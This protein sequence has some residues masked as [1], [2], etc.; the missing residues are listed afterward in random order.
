MRAGPYWP[1]NRILQH[2][3]RLHHADGA[4]QFG[5]LVAH[6]IGAKGRAGLHG[7]GSH[8]LRQVILNH[9]AQRSGFL[10]I[11]AAALHAD[12]FR[13]GDLHVVHVPAIPQRLE[14]AVAEA[15]CQDV[16]DGFFTEVMVDAIDFGFFES[17]VQ[18]VAELLG[19]G[20]VVTERLF[21]DDAAPALPPLPTLALARP[22]AMGM[23]WLGCAER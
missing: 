1:G 7:D 16:L 5:S 20:Q 10:I 18:F 12:R 13:S 15:E 14:D 19:A 3:L 22:C 23:Y 9:V 2:F 4:Q 17:A 21:D 8:H 11:R 6:G